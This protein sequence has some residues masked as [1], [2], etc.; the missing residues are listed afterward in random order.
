MYKQRVNKRSI[1][2]LIIMP[3]LCVVL[4]GCL[5]KMLEEFQKT[6]LMGQ[7]VKP[8]PWGMGTTPEG[9][10]LY[11][12]GWNEGCDSGLAAYGNGRYK[13]SYTFTQDWRLVENKEYY[14]GWKQGYGYCRWY[15]YNW[16]RPWRE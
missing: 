2:T 10:P 6:T 3:F 8:R 14:G 12:K 4:S 5:P 13:V 15:A 7:I 9:P 11:Q 1:V 16:V